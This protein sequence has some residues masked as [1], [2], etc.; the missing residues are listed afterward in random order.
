[1]RGKIRLT[2]A[3]VTHKTEGRMKINP[4]CC[5]SCGYQFLI[6]DERSNTPDDLQK[7]RKMAHREKMH[8]ASN[9]VTEC[10]QCKYV[11]P[12]TEHPERVTFEMVPLEQQF[13][14]IHAVSDMIKSIRRAAKNFRASAEVLDVTRLIDVISDTDAG[15]INISLALDD[16]LLAIEEL[17]EAVNDAAAV[18]K[19]EVTDYKARR[20]EASKLNTTTTETN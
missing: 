5:A 9:L 15:H 4:D 11:F 1:M 17:R 16:L 8:F 13:A 2:A 10:P 3:P 19:E 7:A 20:E 14:F 12:E 18:L 6:A